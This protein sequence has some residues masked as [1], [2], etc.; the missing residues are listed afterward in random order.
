MNPDPITV[1][2][3]LP[4]AVTVNPRWLRFARDAAGLAQQDV[5]QRMGVSACE[6][7]KVERGRIKAP[8]GLVDRLVKLY[9]MEAE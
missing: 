3:L 7:S 5:A 8:P 9:G 1:D 2:Y 6:L 4:D